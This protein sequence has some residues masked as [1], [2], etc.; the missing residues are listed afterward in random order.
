MLESGLIRSNARLVEIL[1]AAASEKTPLG[2]FERLKM[3][4][5]TNRNSVA[6]SARYKI[7]S[8]FQPPHTLLLCGDTLK[9]TRLSL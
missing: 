9:T 8:F 7:E 4:E 2:F 5:K 6:K 3:G 1:E